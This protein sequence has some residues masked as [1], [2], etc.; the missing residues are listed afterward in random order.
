MVF[1][2]ELEVRFDLEP[3]IIIITIIIVYA[4]P[5]LRVKRLL[6]LIMSQTNLFSNCIAVLQYKDCGHRSQATWILELTQ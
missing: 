1:L 3:I 2:I 6:T 4:L 5:D